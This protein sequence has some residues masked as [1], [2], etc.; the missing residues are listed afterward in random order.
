VRFGLPVAGPGRRAAAWLID[1]TIRAA[2]AGAIIACAAIGGVEGKGASIGIVLLLLFV[3]EWGYYVFC[4][5]FLRGSSP[6]KAALGLRVIKEGGFPITLLDSFLRNLLRAA[7]FLPFGFALG[8]ISMALDGRCRRL[9]D[10][11]AGTLVVI[12]DKAT[13]GQPLALN[14][15]QEELDALPRRPPV[16]SDELEAIELF[17][18]RS[19]TL[20]VARE[21]ELAQMLAPRL[22]ARMGLPV[23]DGARFL[24]LTYARVRGYTGVVKS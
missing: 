19:G 5:A 10:M 6:G 23:E 11:V 16:T 3:L 18:R 1:A 8:V 22:A 17:L 21:A 4:E 15:T 7:D 24:A 2:I 12:E 13:V 9:G 20:S 14:F